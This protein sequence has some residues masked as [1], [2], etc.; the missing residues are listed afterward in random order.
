M[1][2]QENWLWTADDEMVKMYLDGGERGA[3]TTWQASAEYV[4]EFHGGHT[5]GNPVYIRPTGNS[6]K[7][8][9]PKVD[10]LNK[11]AHQYTSITDVA[12]DGKLTGALS[13]G[14]QD[15]IVD[16]I[17]NEWYHFKLM[18]TRFW[19]DD[20]VATTGTLSIEEREW[21]EAEMAETGQ[22]DHEISRKLLWLIIDGA[23]KTT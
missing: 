22:Q 9:I 4:F 1:P 15:E 18:I 10:T 21:Q 2:W 17:Q 6:D 3:V 7:A 12:N 14:A 13:S 5:T 20:P 8:N 19:N 16:I 11:Y 23:K